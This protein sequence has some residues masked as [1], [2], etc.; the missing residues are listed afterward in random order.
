MCIN[1]KTL[2]DYFD[3]KQTKKNY[4]RTEHG[5]GLAVGRRKLHRPL[6]TKK[7]IHLILS[8]DKA[9][10]PLSFLVPKNKL[11]IQQVLKGKSKK[12]GVVIGDQA[13]VGN[14]LH[15]K[16]K[17]TSRETFQKFLKSVTTLIARKLTGARRGRPFG[18]FW[19]GLAYTRVL[20]SY[21]EELNLR[22]YFI[23]NRLEGGSTTAARERFL[24]IHRDWVRN[25]FSSA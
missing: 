24:K 1:Q 6:S 17:M 2:F 9:K 13:N 22:G 3:Q 20:T 21:T 12:F 15:I 10:G 11:I 16:F 7:W 19:R 23:A 25:R 4:A 18:R 5:G 8:S 14:H